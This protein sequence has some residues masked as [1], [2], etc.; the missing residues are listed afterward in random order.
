MGYTPA[1]AWEAKLKPQ[2][3]MVGVKTGMTTVSDSDAGGIAG[4]N[5]R[6]P[7]PPPAREK[8]V[9]CELLLRSVC[10]KISAPVKGERAFA[11]RG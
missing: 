7:L 8:W 5:F 4:G 2:G 10:G 1:P 6:L 9:C 11:C 3:S